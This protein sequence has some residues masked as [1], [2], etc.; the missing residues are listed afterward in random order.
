MSARAVRGCEQSA[1]GGHAS[2]SSSPEL[3]KASCWVVEQSAISNSIAG[4]RVLLSS[5]ESPSWANTVTECLPTS[6]SCRTTTAVDGDTPSGEAAIGTRRCASVTAGLRWTTATD[7]NVAGTPPS[8]TSTAS[9]TRRNDVRAGGVHLTT[10]CG[11][12]DDTTVENTREGP[13]LPAASTALMRMLVVPSGSPFSTRGP[14]A[15][16]QYSPAAGAPAGATVSG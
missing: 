8:V 3:S 10:D 6:R 2:H 9:A 16:A 7:P 13:S 14:V 4:G 15:Q 11:R 1:P 12:C 5:G